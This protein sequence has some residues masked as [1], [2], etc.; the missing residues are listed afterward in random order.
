MMPHDT[1]KTIKELTARLWAFPFEEYL[2]SET[3]S[4]FCRD[5]DLGDTWNEYLELSRDTPDLYGTNVIKNAFVL[6]LYYIFHSRPGE[7]PALL[8]G[9]VEDFSRGISCVLPLDD[10]KSDLM[11]L[12]YSE[13]E[14]EHAFSGVKADGKATPGPRDTCCPD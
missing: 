9:I 7:F 4:R 6:F 11:Q 12:G 10:L 13:L 3:F 1:K 5:H 8:G 2:S 14:T